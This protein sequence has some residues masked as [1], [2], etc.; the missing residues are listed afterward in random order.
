MSKKS[1]I[2][3]KLNE[4]KQTDRRKLLAKLNRKENKRKEA[5][6]IL[7]VKKTIY[8]EPESI[9]DIV[10]SGNAEALENIP[11]GLQEFRNRIKSFFE[12]CCFED[13]SAENLK[14]LLKYLHKINPDFLN[15]PLYFNGICNIIHFK[16]HWIRNIYRWKSKTNNTYR[17]F[18]ELIKYLFDKH[19]DAP[20]FLI[21]SWLDPIANS[22]FNGQYIFM[23]IGAGK[24]IRTCKFLP[25]PLNKKEAKYFYTTPEGY[26]INGALRRCQIFA[27]GGNSR[28]V[29]G[30]LRTYLLNSFTADSFWKT[31]FEFFIK[32]PMIDTEQYP[33][34][35]DYIS[36]IKFADNAI[37]RHF[38][39]KG[40]SPYNLFREMNVWLLSRKRIENLQKVNWT[41]FKI[42]N[43]YYEIKKDNKLKKYKIEQIINSDD[44]LHEAKV[45]DHC[46]FTYLFS[47]Y[48]GKTSIW[49][50]AEE[51]E[52]GD[53]KK[54]LTI[55]L[56]NDGFINEIRGKCNRS[57]NREEYEI[58]KEWTIRE[59]LAISGHLILRLNE[60]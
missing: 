39:I 11:A 37:Y 6:K 50:M 32:N 30:V 58:I 35:V 48:K 15:K 46:V 59:R 55:E 42:N 38:K 17:Q 36:H 4:R 52:N 14:I 43:Y 54:L 60:E 8:R 10:Y 2:K 53:F 33:N 28:I 25:V 22:E 29:K 26:S 5:D 31:V 7:S 24:N 40:R 12:K 27:L 9:I 23:H 18:T 56:K 57:F 20:L 21:K 44:L 16:N 51:N 47:C 41:P 45:M 49:K 3:H 34:I 13:I 1:P 19:N